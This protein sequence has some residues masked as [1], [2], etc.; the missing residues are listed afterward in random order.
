MN[1]LPPG[2]YVGL[3][4]EQYHDDP[5]IGSSGI[6]LL[7]ERPRRYWFQSPLNPN[8]IKSKTTPA[9]KFGTAFH[10]L[11]L[12]PEKFDY[13][14]KFG[15]DQSQIAGTLG[16]GEYKRLIAMKDQLFSKPR[17]AALLSEGISEVSVFWRD[18]ATG[19]MC[20]VR[21]DKFAAAWILDLKTA[22]SITD[23]ALYWAIHDL[24]Y[25]VSGAM[26]SLA[27][28]ELKKMIRAGYQMPPE[29]SQEFIDTFVGFDNQLFAFMIQ[30][31]DAPYFSRCP[32][33]TPGVAAIGR[34]KFRDGLA[35]YAKCERDGWETDDYDDIEDMDMDRYSNTA[36]QYS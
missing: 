20:K 17:R 3:P 24:G 2:C 13:K 31:K 34:N 8:R 19:I 21:F 33:L 7:I 26:Y 14:I 28:R 36:S 18:E 10:T 9:M 27:A 32:I 23:K 1:G 12:E 29:F 11:I 35:A 25:D 22:L 15:V 30:E 6:K 16:D 4:S 5:A